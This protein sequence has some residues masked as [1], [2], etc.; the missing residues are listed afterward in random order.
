MSDTI[1]IALY[2]G[3]T[4]AI[5]AVS[6]IS[7]QKNPIPS[8]VATGGLFL[9]LVVIASLW[10]SDIAKAFAGLILV[11]NVI[12]HGFPLIAAVGK[13]VT[14]LQIGVSQPKATDKP[15]AAT[16]GS[17]GQSGFGAGGSAGGGGGG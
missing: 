14:G 5:N 16:P 6:S 7:K 10:R 3:T 11:V 2:M 17:Q 8:A 1:D 4:A 15:H 9:F 13:L 12:A